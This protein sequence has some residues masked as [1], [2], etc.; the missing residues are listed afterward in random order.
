MREDDGRVYQDG[1]S[2]FLDGG[3]AKQGHIG[4]KKR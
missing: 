1:E 4:P 2:A 3:K